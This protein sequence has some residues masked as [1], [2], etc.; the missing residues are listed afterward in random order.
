MLFVLSVVCELADLSFVQK[1]VHVVVARP[2]A[3]IGLTQSWVPAISIE[4]AGVVCS[5]E[6]R[7]DRTD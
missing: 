2:F 6:Y 5:V 7:R 3:K 4:L 1:L